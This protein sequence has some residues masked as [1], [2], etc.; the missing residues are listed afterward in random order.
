MPRGGV[1]GTTCGKMTW[2][3]FLKAVVVFCVVACL[4]ES[5]LVDGRQGYNLPD[6]AGTEFLLAF[7][8]TS[9]DRKALI[10][11]TSYLD[12]TVQIFGLN[13]QQIGSNITLESANLVHEET[14]TG[15]EVTGTGRL[16]QFNSWLIKSDDEITVYGRSSGDGYMA[17]P[18]DV[19]GK[20]YYVAS[21]QGNLL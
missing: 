7:P 3:S 16:G 17:L 13:D 11:A 18:T 8:S 6:N 14:L 15:A 9:S 2:L 10:R 4:L 21:Y 5:P 20:E 12:T 19:L 1:K